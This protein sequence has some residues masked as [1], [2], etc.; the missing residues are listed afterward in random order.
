MIR[1]CFY[2]PQGP[3]DLRPLRRRASLA[4]TRAPAVAGY[5]PIYFVAVPS[6]RASLLLAA[7]LGHGP[8]RSMII[9][10]HTSRLVFAHTSGGEKSGLR[11]AILYITTVPE[12][13]GFR[14]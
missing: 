9:L 12:S 1:F 5:G 14:F 13:D 3:P 11:V 4:T 6:G 7:A 10:L 8:N 2:P